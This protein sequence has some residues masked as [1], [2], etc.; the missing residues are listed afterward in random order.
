MRDALSGTDGTQALPAGRVYVDALSAAQRRVEQA[1]VQEI[2]EQ[3]HEDAVR[4]LVER[5]A[6]PQRRRSSRDDEQGAHAAQSTAS[7]PDAPGASRRSSTVPHQ[8]LVKQGRGELDVPT[9]Q[10][11]R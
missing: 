6:V 4:R 9:L 11:Y 2:V 5:G 3:Q 10:P 7:V 8:N 1:D